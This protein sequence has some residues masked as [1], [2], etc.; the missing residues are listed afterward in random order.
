MIGLEQC[1]INGKFHYYVTIVGY[2][3]LKISLIKNVL[4]ARLDLFFLKELKEHVSFVI[5]ENIV[6]EN[7][8]LLVVLVL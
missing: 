8:V 4:L 3:F 5:M 2:L 1:I 6:M 7:H